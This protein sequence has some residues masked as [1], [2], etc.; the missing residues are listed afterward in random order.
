MGARLCGSLGFSPAHP[1]RPVFL[2]KQTRCLSLLG[3]SQGLAEWASEARGRGERESEAGVSSGVVLQMQ[4][5]RAREDQGVPL[6]SGLP[7]RLLPA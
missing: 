4:W 3:P 6:V 2:G 7:I 5:A 1:S